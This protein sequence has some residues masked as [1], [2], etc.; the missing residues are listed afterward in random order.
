MIPLNIGFM[1][2][3]ILKKIPSY[4]YRN[5]AAPRFY[6][7]RDRKILSINKEIKNKFREKRCFI[8]G[9]GPSTAEIDLGKLKNEYT[10]VM[11]EFDKNPQYR[12][13]RPKFHILADTNYAHEGTEYWTSKFKEKNQ[14]VDRATTLILNMELK[15]FA[16]KNNLFKNHKVYYMGTRGIFTKNLPFNIGL[17]KYVPQPKNSV[18]MCLMAASWM[19]FNE[20]YLLGCEHNFLSQPLGPSKSLAWGHSYNHEMSEL[21]NADQETLKKYITDKE[22]NFNYE[23]NMASTLQ[24]F[25]SYRLFY[26]KARKMYPGLKIFNATPNSFLDVFPMLNFNDIKGL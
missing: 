13:L 2:T 26:A 1:V 9:G 14:S 12:N 5:Y 16:E 4:L 8:I 18:L 23:A 24:L 17:D 15:A 19:G 7:F 25:R 21:K 6:N 10:F 22:M 11:S 20:I 3:S